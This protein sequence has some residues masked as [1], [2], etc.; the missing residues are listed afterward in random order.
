MKYYIILFLI[1][2][3]VQFSFAQTQNA[4]NYQGVLRDGQGQPQPNTNVE[5]QFTIEA[6]YATSG[7]AYREN[8]VTNTNSLG[9]FSVNIGEG[10]TDGLS[11]SFESIEWAN[12]NHN[13][14]VEISIEGGAFRALGDPQPL[15]SVP[16]ALH[17]VGPWR[18]IAPSI[19]ELKDPT[20]TNSVIMGTDGVGNLAMEFGAYKEGS[21]TYLDFKNSLEEDF[22]VR[23]SH[24]GGNGLTLTG[25]LGIN[26]DDF[27][28]GKLV[29]S[30]AENYSMTNF[31]YLNNAVPVG[32]FPETVDENFSIYA[33]NRIA[34]VQFNA[35]SDERIK[36][37][38]GLSN[39]A[40]DLAILKNIKIYDYQLKDTITQKSDLEKK[41]VG[42]QIAKVFPQAVTSNNIEIIPDIMRFAKADRGIVKLKN[43]ELVEGDKVRI[44][45]EEG[46]KDLAIVST[47]EDSFQLNQDYTGD[48]F[49]YGKEV[50]DFHIVDYEEIAMLNVS[51]TQAIS[52]QLED[53]AQV[54]NE[55][56]EAIEN[57]KKQ[58]GKVLGILAQKSN[59]EFT[60]K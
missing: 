50:N 46:F 33:T 19:V 40:K 48:L 27:S 22:D 23:L 60:G 32:I 13:L 49:V 52:Q 35:Y 18:T 3:F 12:G 45:F 30:G 10:V 20:T 11:P 54:I 6:E 8:H 26:T 38:L 47:K 15:I 4:F 53:Q 1:H 17:A 37:I 29:V 57:L 21:V 43:H 31:A 14:K 28:K 9:I 34:A 44:Y 36:D 25:A 2:L 41:V 24:F 39:G 42:Q 7:I 59:Q 5:L 58:L 51:A 55:Q 56:Q 16:Y